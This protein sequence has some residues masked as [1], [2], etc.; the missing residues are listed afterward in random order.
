MALVS[1]E[2]LR[3]AVHPIASLA[4]SLGVA[5]GTDLEAR[6]HGLLEA[7]RI[8]APP[9][10]NDLLAIAFVSL[11]LAIFLLVWPGSALH[12]TAESLLGVFA[13]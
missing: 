5:A 1:V 6:V 3:A 10:A 7:D 8:P 11:E 9:L 2:R 13:R 12:H 4:P